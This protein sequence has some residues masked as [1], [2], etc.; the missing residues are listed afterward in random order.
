MAKIAD[1]NTELLKR[2]KNVPNVTESDASDWV[3]TSVI[4]HGFAKVGDSLTNVEVSDDSVSLVLLYA[5][6]EGARSIS[7][8]TAFYFSYSDGNESVDKTNVSEQ[9]RKLSHDLMADYHRKRSQSS[10]SQFRI[11]KRVDRP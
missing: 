7:L 10:G 6:A 9:Y 3:E 2:F 11:M 5:Q 4:E 1:L 8:S